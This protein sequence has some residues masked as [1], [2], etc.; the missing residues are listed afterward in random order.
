M[1]ATMRKV[2]LGPLALVLWV[3]VTGGAGAQDEARAVIARAVAAQGGEDVLGRDVARA[4]KLKGIL[5]GV[6]E[7]VTFTGDLLWESRGR[8]KVTLRVEMSG[9]H[10][11]LIEVL[12]G[13]AGWM[14]TECRV[15]DLKP[16]VLAALRRSAY[17]D[18]VVTLVP[19]LKDPAF[20]LTPLGESTVDGRPAL[21]VKVASAGQPDV[22]LSFDRASGLL[23]KSAHRGTSQVTKKE[24]LEETVYG[25]YREPDLGAADEQALKAAGIR[26]GGPEVLDFLR[27]QTPPA[28]DPARVRAL[29][30]QLG[31]ESFVLRRQASAGLVALGAGAV[32]WL[33]EVLKDD[34]AEVAQRA[35][36]CLDRIGPQADGALVAAAV[37]LAALRRP[38]GAA[39]VL[40]T[41]VARTR[42]EALA[43]EARAALAALADRDGKPD[44]ALR[45]ALEDGDPVRQAAA[46]AALG[47]DG[48]AY[49]RLPGRRLYPTGLKLPM[50]VVTYSDG[51]KLFERETVGV[52]YF[53]EFD[54]G[55]FARPRETAPPA[56]GGRP[57]PPAGPGGG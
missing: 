53:N 33:Q 46:A 12:D 48:G 38:D 55:V 26:A 47:R 28:V 56:P 37:R 42:D 2:L 6:D 31:D 17:V 50:K 29:I 9:V 54:D 35:R 15:E 25:D 18:R 16:E 21:A 49:A 44:P 4:L 51:K 39:E 3:G 13:A 40:L 32:P 52:E 23:V 8:A 41:L 27:R 24:V 10:V 57:A 36:E 19:L 20:T 11:T 7:S 14:S 5:A 43:R 30:R 1:E 34:D 45:R 22:T